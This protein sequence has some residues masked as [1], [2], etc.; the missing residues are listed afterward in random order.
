MSCHTC[1][2]RTRA[3]ATVRADREQWEI[4]G[5]SPPLGGRRRA[6]K[7]VH[8]VRYLAEPG[9]YRRADA[10]AG[11]GAGPGLPGVEFR[12][13]VD[14]D[15][16]EHQQTSKLSGKAALDIARVQRAITGPEN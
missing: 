12:G 1:H 6:H 5:P 11:A 14:R 13:I 9:R 10:G 2:V 8:S 7:D 3:C 4:Q 16:L 15:Y